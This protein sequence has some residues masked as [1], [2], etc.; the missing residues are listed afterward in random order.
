MLLLTEPVDCR[1]SAP[2]RTREMIV[3]FRNSNVNDRIVTAQGSESI[4]IW[5]IHLFIQN[6]D[7]YYQ[8]II[9][10]SFFISSLLATSGF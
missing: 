4:D 7:N 8:E 5:S 3:E 2:S 6:S 10:F 9:P 1:L